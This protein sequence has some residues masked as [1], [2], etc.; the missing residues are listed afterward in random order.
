MTIASISLAAQIVLLNFVIQAGYFPMVGGTSDKM[1]GLRC[2]SLPI[3]STEYNI[4]CL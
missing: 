3:L 1:A 4:C 2:E